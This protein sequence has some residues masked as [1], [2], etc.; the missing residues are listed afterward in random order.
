MKVKED[1]T[2][3]AKAA[4]PEK[5]PSAQAQKIIG[6]VGSSLVKKVKQREAASVSVV[7]VGDISGK[8]LVRAKKQSSLAKK[9]LI[10]GQQVNQKKADAILNVIEIQRFAPSPM[11]KSVVAERTRTEKKQKL[12]TL[13]ETIE[14][15]KSRTESMNYANFSVQQEKRDNERFRKT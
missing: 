3:K 15:G 11:K 10:G 7:I 8:N 12:K 6:K 9:I 2:I 13:T 1:P 14:A 4:K 5:P